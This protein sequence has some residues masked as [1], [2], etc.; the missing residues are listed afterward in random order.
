MQEA[1]NTDAQKS[2][3]INTIGIVNYGAGNIFSLTAALDRQ[4]ISYEMIESPEDFD[5]YERYIIPGVGHA[6]AAMQ[7]LEES[8]MV[9]K[10]LATKKPVL[11][12]CV[13]MQLLTEFSEEGNSRLLGIAPVKTRL[14]SELLKLKIPHTGWNKV[15]ALADNELFKGLNKET[16]F[17]FVHS[18]FIEFNPN[19]AIASTGYGVTF[20]AALKKDNYYG[21]QFH[22]EKSGEA[23][24]QILKNFSLI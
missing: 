15:S 9:S 1:Q 8:G 20:S 19:F 22:P 16:Y 5:K 24:E 7:K 11:G 2:K 17:Y 4:S 23:G 21:V 6:G 12:I 10:I 13:G 18:Y 14:F 3:S